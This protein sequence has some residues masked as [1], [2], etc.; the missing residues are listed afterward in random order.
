MLLQGAVAGGVVGDAVLP[1]APEDAAPGASEGADR[2]GV[3]VA[4]GDRAG[5][6]VGRPGVPV[7]GGVGERAERVAQ[8]F[9]ACPAEAGDLAFAG[10][11]RDRGLAGVAGERVA[12][13]VAGAAVADLGEQRRRR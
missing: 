11:D 4:A 6:V 7:A 12:G 3:V 13:G 8:A 2:A 1:A 9:V 10:L 5:V